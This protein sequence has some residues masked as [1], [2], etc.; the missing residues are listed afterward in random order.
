MCWMLWSMGY[1][2]LP[3]LLLLSC[4]AH[5]H[6][7]GSSLQQGEQ[8][9]ASDAALL[10]SLSLLPLPLTFYRR[11]T[12]TTS[13]D[14]FGSVTATDVVAAVREYG[15]VLEE[16]QGGFAGVEKG[17]VKSLGTFECELI[18]RAC[19]AGWWWGCACADTDSCFAYNSQ[20]RFRSRLLNRPSRLRWRFGKKRVQVT[21]SRRLEG[22]YWMTK[23]CYKLWLSTRSALGALS[24]L[25]PF[26]PD[27]SSAI[28]QSLEHP[29]QSFLA[30]MR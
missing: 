12:G 29:R 23:L 21:R 27:A 19:C 14:L 18:L 4:L 10:Q 3:L 1:A 7:D 22:C 20:T 11:T 8:A 16:S 28:R 24:Q 15:I 17:R 26:K 13:T 5:D 2:F 30:C 6:T 25:S 9:R